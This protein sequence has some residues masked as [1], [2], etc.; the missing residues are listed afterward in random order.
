[1]AT[2]PHILTIYPCLLHGIQR[3]KEPE[4]W[5]PFFDLRLYGRK[6]VSVKNSSSKHGIILI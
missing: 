4:S 3:Q 1:M 5:K 6:K 2:Y